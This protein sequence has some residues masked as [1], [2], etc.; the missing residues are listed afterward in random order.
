MW[1]RGLKFS[2]TFRRWSHRSRGLCG[3][4]DWN[5]KRICHHTAGYK[6]RLMWPRGLKSFKSKYFTRSHSSRG[7]QEPRGLKF[8]NKRINIFLGP[9]E[10]YVA[11]GIEVMTWMCCRNRTICRGLFGLVDWNCMEPTDSFILI[12]SR[13]M[14]PRRHLQVYRNFP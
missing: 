7:L 8:C 2:I 6:S 12:M 5:R 1:P 14:Q 13:F 10:A 9:V 4:V 3:L 11:S